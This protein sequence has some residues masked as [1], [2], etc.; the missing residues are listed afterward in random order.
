MWIPSGGEWVLSDPELI[1]SQ[2]LASDQWKTA[3]S[4]IL[5]NLMM[6]Y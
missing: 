1:Q 3:L 6:I 2:E 4:R 5:V